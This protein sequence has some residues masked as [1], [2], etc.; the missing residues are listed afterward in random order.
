MGSK[1]GSSKMNADSHHGLYWVNL[2]VRISARAGT[3]REPPRRDPWAG[4][5]IRTHPWPRVFCHRGGR[6]PG[7]WDWLVCSN[8]SPH[9]TQKR[10]GG[11][12]VVEGYMPPLCVRRREVRFCMGQQVSLQ[13]TAVAGEGVVEFQPGDHVI[14]CYQAHCGECAGCKAADPSSAMMILFVASWCHRKMSAVV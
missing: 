8:T 7:S 6:R 12:S 14:P 4:E 9:C 3:D 5:A 11:V 2:L 13:S 10:G 1:S